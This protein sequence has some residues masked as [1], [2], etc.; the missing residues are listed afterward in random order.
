MI[1]FWVQEKNL[2]CVH[3]VEFLTFFS[4]FMTAPLDLTP[5]ALNTFLLTTAGRDVIGKFFQ[6][7]FRGLAGS[8]E[9]VKGW[10]DTQK[11]V[12]RLFV[13]IMEARR[14]TRWLMSLNT[15][16]ALYKPA[17]WDDELLFRLHQLGMLWWQVL[18][19]Y[20]WLVETQTFQ[21]DAK[22]MKKISFTGFVL[23]S[24]LGVIYHMKKAITM[25]SDDSA[26]VSENNVQLFKHFLSLINTLHVSEIYTT[27]EPIC[28]YT[29]ALVA[30]I[31]INSRYPRVSLKQKQ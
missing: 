9:G 11:K 7:L 20:R 24:L 18:D 4:T 3:K 8:L 16:L 23:A 10:E 27:S 13:R 21:G 15:F 29:G 6:Y 31:D 25:K 22:Q 14:T 5:T 12:R 1:G 28:G 19:H 30:L 17:I 26:K 2:G